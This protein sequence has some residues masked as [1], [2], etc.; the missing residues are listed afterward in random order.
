ME[1]NITKKGL[2]LIAGH[3]IKRIGVKGFKF[4]EIDICDIV[5]VHQYNVEDIQ[6]AAGQM[7][8]IMH[9]DCLPLIKLGELDA[10]TAG[11]INLNDNKIVYI[12]LDRQKFFN[13]YY[14]W[15]EIL[16]IVAHELSHKMLW[17]HGFKETSQKIEYVT[18]ACAVFVGFGELLRYAAI[19]AVSS[20]TE[21]QQFV[22]YTTTTTTTNYRTLGYLK[23]WQIDYLRYKFFKIRGP[24]FEYKIKEFFKKEWVEN[25]KYVLLCIFLLS[26]LVI[27]VWSLCDAIIMRIK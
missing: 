6:K 12:T 7:C 21:K 25:V 4:K 15:Y 14:S 22:G 2:D 8:T 1:N 5:P 9:L 16:A 10:Y 13:R 24:Y 17:I 27:A 18:D 26:L 19:R 23:R 3:I 11:S 20:K